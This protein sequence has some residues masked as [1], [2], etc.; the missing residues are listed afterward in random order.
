MVRQPIA[1]LRER[2]QTSGHQ[3]QPRSLKNPPLPPSSCSVQGHA[4]NCPFVCNR[5]A[6]YALR[7]PS[8]LDPFSFPFPRK[9]APLR[10]LLDAL[11]LARSLLVELALL[12]LLGP[13]G[14]LLASLHADNAEQALPSGKYEREGEALDQ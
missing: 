8:L 4:Y 11:G 10:V 9:V 13:A 1:R 7:R 5:C 14:V 12:A 6:P 2:P 3:E